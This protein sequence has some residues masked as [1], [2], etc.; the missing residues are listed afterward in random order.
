MANKDLEQLVLDTCKTL[1]L[2]P[3]QLTTVYTAINLAYNMGWLDRTSQDNEDIL[4]YTTE[5]LDEEKEI[6]E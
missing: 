3:E 5:S 2:K 1:N 4:D 6:Y